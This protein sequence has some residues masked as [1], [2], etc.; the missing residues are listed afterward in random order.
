MPELSSEKVSVWFIP[1]GKSKNF[2]EKSTELCAWFMPEGIEE[3]LSF[4]V[5]GS[6]PRG[7]LQV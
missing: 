6:A 1:G 7:L 5:A 3:L 4:L 2:F